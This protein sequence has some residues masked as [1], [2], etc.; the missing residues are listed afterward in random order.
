MSAT[1]VDVLIEAVREL[2]E[3][4]TQRAYATLS[5]EHGLTI[6]PVPGHPDRALV[7]AHWRD[8]AE[9]RATVPVKDLLALL[10]DR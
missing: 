9:D 4:Y 5:I 10:E 6:Q 2:A 1:N 8:A 7:P 3:E